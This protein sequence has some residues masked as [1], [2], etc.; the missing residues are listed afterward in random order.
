VGTFIALVP[1]LTPQAAS[2]RV[3]VVRAVPGEP[4]LKGGD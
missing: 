2:L 3:P 1:A 4:A